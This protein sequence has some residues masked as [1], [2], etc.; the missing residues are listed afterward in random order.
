MR[1]LI[2]VQICLQ[3]QTIK[4]SVENKSEREKNIYIAELH[5]SFQCRIVFHAGA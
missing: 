5:V 4:F 2:R 3:I 1:N